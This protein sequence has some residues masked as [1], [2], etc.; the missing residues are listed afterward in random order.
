MQERQAHELVPCGVAVIIDAQ[1]A[2]EE[3]QRVLEV[4]HRVSGRQ[5]LGYAES[6]GGITAQDLAATCCCS[7]LHGEPDFTL[8]ISC[9]SCCF[10]AQDACEGSISPAG[11]S[12]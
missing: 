8:H 2:L 10:Y 11:V 9:E 3:P 5:I 6:H 4:C 1:T 12:A 7:N